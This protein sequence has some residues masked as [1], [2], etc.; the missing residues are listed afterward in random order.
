MGPVACVVTVPVT[1]VA[2]VDIVVD[3]GVFCG[4]V[5]RTVS[6]CHKMISDNATLRQNYESRRARNQTRRSGVTSY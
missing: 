6:A 1:V 4:S 5:C 3:R 2:V